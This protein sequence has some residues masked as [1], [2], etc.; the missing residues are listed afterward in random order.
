MTSE[1]SVEFSVRQISPKNGFYE[2][3]GN[4]YFLTLEGNLFDRENS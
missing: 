1:T 2:Q 4:I 3:P